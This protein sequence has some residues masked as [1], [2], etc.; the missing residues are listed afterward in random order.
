MCLL[1]V[2]FVL[3]ILKHFG[4]E[5][6]FSAS[7]WSSF[8]S[9]NSEEA[10]FS[11]GSL[12]SFVSPSMFTTLDSSFETASVAPIVTASTTFPTAFFSEEES[13]EQQEE[14]LSCSSK[15]VMR[16][17]IWAQHL[18]VQF[19]SLCSGTV[20]LPGKILRISVRNSR[21]S[22]SNSL[23]EILVPRS[24]NSRRTSRMQEAC[25]NKLESLSRT[26]SCSSTKLRLPTKMVKR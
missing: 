24:I 10:T 9:S 25:L 23:M 21:D 3:M 16:M 8:S 15:T 7:L 19:T 4:Q 18:V 12:D 2:N 5:R 11:L 13:S 1:K 22:N 17:T 20:E 14:S 6:L 26:N